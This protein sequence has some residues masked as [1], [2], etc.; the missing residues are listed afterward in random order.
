[1][2]ANEWA[3][4]IADVQQKRYEKPTKEWKT[5]SEICSMLKL[6][7]SQA[8]KRI[9]TLKKMGAVETRKFYIKNVLG[10]YFPILHYKL[11]KK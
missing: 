3:M 8:G 1:M 10:V 7:T 4:A 9:Q 2:S 5:M 6:G 11:I